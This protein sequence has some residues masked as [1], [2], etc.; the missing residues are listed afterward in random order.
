MLTSIPFFPSKLTRAVSTAQSL[1]LVLCADGLFFFGLITGSLHSSHC[2]SFYCTSL[3][4]TPINLQFTNPLKPMPV[5]LISKGGL[6]FALL[7]VDEDIRLFGRG[8][9]GEFGLWDFAGVPQ[10]IPRRV[11]SC[12]A[13]HRIVK[14]L[15]GPPL[16]FVVDN[17]TFAFGD[18][19][20]GLLSLSSIDP[21]SPPKLGPSK[22]PFHIPPEALLT[23]HPPLPP[24]PHRLIF[25]TPFEALNSG[26]TRS[27]TQ[28]ILSLC[29]QP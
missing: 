22:K 20:G 17:D 23:P 9:L 1:T 27:P 2:T 26:C 10:H 19:F 18:A 29:L 12:M 7:G 21:T 14:I 16:T 8:P 4:C 28:P 25:M 15:C 24:P 13:E 3:H 6:H 11:R 5:S